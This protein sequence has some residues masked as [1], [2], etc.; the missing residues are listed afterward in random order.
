MHLMNDDVLSLAMRFRL[1]HVDHCHDST[2]CTRH[3]GRGEHVHHSRPL[4]SLL[5]YST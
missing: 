5:L 2:F 3:A 4:L 1:S